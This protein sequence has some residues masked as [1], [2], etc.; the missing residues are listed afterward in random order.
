MSSNII[1]W[2]ALFL[3]VIDHVG[4][5]LPGS[6]IY[7]RYA[8][9]LS[10][11]L[12]LFGVI[13]SLHYTH[14]RV[15]YLLRLYV[16]GIIMAVLDLCLNNIIDKPYRYITNNIFITFL[17]IGIIIHVIEKLINFRKEGIK[18]AVAFL[19]LQA[20]STVV[21]ILVGSWIPL[22]GINN[23]MGAF[24]PNIIWNEGSLFF[25]ILGVIMYFTKDNKIVMS[26]CYCFFSLFFLAK[27]LPD[28]A[29]EDVWF[30]NYQWMMIFALPIMLCYNQKRGASIKYFFYVFYPIHIVLLYI[31]GNIMERNV[32]KL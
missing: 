1:K 3:M 4:E 22:Y 32:L 28:L 12:F 30:I 25:I 31:V 7:F 9:R 5:F 19:I 2:I 13:W 6:S 23:F 11:P 26:V 17:L 10:F 16:A 14:D 20:I 27:C 8:G 18:L 21:C 24:L 29:Y 15:K